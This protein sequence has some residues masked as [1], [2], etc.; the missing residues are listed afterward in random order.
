MSIL[1]KAYTMRQNMKIS[2]ITNQ[3]TPTKVIT[4][5]RN[6]I[7]PI[8]KSE[9]MITTNSFPVKSAKTPV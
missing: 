6:T 3:N 4:N 8:S 1:H 7:A 2:A 9:N 5:A